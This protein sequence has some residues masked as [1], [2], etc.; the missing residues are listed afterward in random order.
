[1][2]L[3]PI[4]WRNAARWEFDLRRFEDP[5]A[6]DPPPAPPAGDP[7]AGDPPP[8]DP[9][10]T[11]EQLL[12]EERA[13]TAHW[14]EMAR[15]QEE[16]AKANAEK[17]K[18]YDEH[19]AA[20]QTEL[21]REKARADAAEQRAQQRTDRAVLAEVRALADGF[22]DRDDAI[23]NLAREEGGLARFVSD[24]GDIDTEAINAALAAT[25]EKKPHLKK[26]DAP[27]PPPP[28]DPSLGPRGGG[29]PKDYR[30]ADKKEFDQELAKHGLR[31]R[32]T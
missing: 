15:K 14:K 30:T 18:K 12:E 13:Q 26:S 31:P 11:P 7:P 32:S 29:D 24:D 3:K 27:P 6:G 8:A 4:W 1:M 22:V 28:Q 2:K 9:P 23:A 25:L 19:E 17:A 21:E 20:N 5:P 16:R 10:K